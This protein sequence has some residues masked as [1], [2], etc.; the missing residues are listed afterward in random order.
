MVDAFEEEETQLTP[1]RNQDEW[2]NDPLVQAAKM[3]GAE[4][5]PIDEGR[6]HE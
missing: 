5:R 2:A 6:E 3:M 1:R 4:V